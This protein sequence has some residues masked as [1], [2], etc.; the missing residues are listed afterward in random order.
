MAGRTTLQE[1][2]SG[3]VYRSP[4]DVRMKFQ[5]LNVAHKLLHDLTPPAS[6]VLSP[7]P[8][9]CLQTHLVSLSLGRGGVPS[10]LLLPHTVHSQF[11]PAYLNVTSSGKPFL[12]TKH[13]FLFLCVY[14]YPMV[15]FVIYY[16]SVCDR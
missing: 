9:P 10:C 11:L 3:S 7:L 13:L 6:P 16:Y 5:I 2:S 15:E 12:T 4:V 1:G 14:P 8:P